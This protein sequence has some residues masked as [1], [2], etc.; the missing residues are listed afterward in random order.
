MKRANSENAQLFQ[1]LA[2][3]LHAGIGVT[4]GLFL[5]AEDAGQQERKLLLNM[6]SQMDRGSSLAE[7]MAHT[8]AFSA[9]DT[10]MIRA[11]QETGRTEEAL[12]ALAGY[13]EER[14]RTAQLIKTSLAYPC[15]ILALMLVVIAVLLIKVLPVFDSVY[16]SLGSGLG[17]IAG[18]LLRFGQTLEALLPGL[19]LLLAAMAIFGLI[20]SL[21]PPVQQRIAVF[22]RSRFGDRGILRTFNNARFARILSMGLRSGMPLEQAMELAQGLLADIPGAAAR[23]RQCTQALAQDRSLAEAMAEAK[24]LTPAM[25]RML[26]TGLRCGNADQVMDQIANRLAQEA[27]DSLATAI[28]RAEPLMVTIASGLVGLI[29]LTVMLPL[30]DIMSTIGG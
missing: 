26:A 5:L 1:G 2:L 7:A 3:L 12:E 20:F 8:G 23:C 16:A 30:M 6:G 19:L 22:W 24:L 15:M 21:C 14:Q 17:G 10:G 27:S 4:E 18:G 29:L 25:S 13:Y 11:G 28:S 9:Y